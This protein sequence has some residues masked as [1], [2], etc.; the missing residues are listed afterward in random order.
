MSL[1][2]DLRLAF[3][4]LRASPIVSIVAALSLALG[5]GANTA[6]FSLVNGLLLRALPVVEPQRLVTISSDM[7]IRLGF[8]A[9]LGWNYALWDQL[10]QRAQAFD[11]ALAWS[12]PRFN[13]SAGGEMQPV[14]G[15]VASD[16]F[17]TTLGVKAALGRTFTTADDVRAGGP[18]GPVVVIS[19]RLWRRRFGGSAGIVGKPLLVEGVPL[20][21]V[22]VTP[23]EFL[24]LETGRSFD[25]PLPLAIEPLIR[26][27]ALI[28]EPSALFR[29]RNR[30]D[31]DLPIARPCW[32]ASAG[33]AILP[34]RRRPASP[35]HCARSIPLLPS[36]SARSRTT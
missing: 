30:P 18:D 9:G 7:A 22:G 31:R 8:K 3:R 19:D 23:P 27:R 35:R 20:T 14:D 2:N 4:A 5:I 1:L 13:L 32:S 6:I 11:G 16:S 15:L 17:F 24:G 33:P 25:V 12:M 10:R 29:S 36:P 26:K 34:R 21:I 28:D